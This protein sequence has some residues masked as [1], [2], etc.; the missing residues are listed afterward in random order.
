LILYRFGKTA[1][2]GCSAA[3][4][5]RDIP[6]S[7]LSWPSELVKCLRG[8]APSKKVFWLSINPDVLSLSFATT[9]HWLLGFITIVVGMQART[10]G[11][12]EPGRWSRRRRAPRKASLKGLSIFLRRLFNFAQKISDRSALIPIADQ[13]S[14]VLDLFFLFA[15]PLFSSQGPPC[16]SCRSRSKRSSSNLR[17]F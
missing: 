11:K 7:I 15:P 10:K 1:C 5:P 3:G 12:D 16:S 6:S 2:R 14:Q 4:R 13:F 9:R 8:Y 17:A